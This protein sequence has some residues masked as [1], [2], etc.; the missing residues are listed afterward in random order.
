MFSARIFGF[1]AAL[2]VFGGVTPTAWAD[3]PRRSANAAY[4]ANMR[5]WHDADAIPAARFTEDGRLI[6]RLRSLNAMGTAEITPQTPDGGFDEAACAEVSRVFADSRTRRQAP[7]DRRLIEMVY[8]IAR[9]FRAGQVTVVSG[10]RAEAGSSNHA[11]GRAVDSLIPGVSDSAIAAYARTLGFAGVGVY[12]AGGF[13]HVDVRTRSFFWVDRSGPGRPSRS[14]RSRRRGRSRGGVN[15]IM[16]E[17]AR[18]SDTEARARGVSPFGGMR[19]A[20]QPGGRGLQA[21]TQAQ[22]ATSEATA[23]DDDE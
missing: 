15:E 10:Y 1:L 12:P 22:G 21:Q 13:V 20:S 3:P 9:H 5:R 19:G 17:L 7:I 14:R 2:A 16:G 18:R 11:Q 6:L 8:Q 23:D 4:R